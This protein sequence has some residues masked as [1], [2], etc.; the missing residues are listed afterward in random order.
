M[1]YPFCVESKFDSRR[2]EF[3]LNGRWRCALPTTAMG[4]KLS[5]DVSRK[6][7][8]IYSEDAA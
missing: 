2:Q 4:I 7:G 6:T 5:F 1:E 3:G 8:A